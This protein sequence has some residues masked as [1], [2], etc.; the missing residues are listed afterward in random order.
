MNDTKPWYAS[1]TVWGGLLAA[2]SPLVRAVGYELDVQQAADLL[3]TLG[4][5]VGG[6]W[7]VWG[8]VRADTLIRRPG[9]PD[10]PA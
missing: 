7:A 9:V 6:A 10:R 5:L 1:G 8:R 4:A 2:V 3:S